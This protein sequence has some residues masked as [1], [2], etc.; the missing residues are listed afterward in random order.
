MRHPGRVSVRVTEG[1]LVVV[2]S[3]VWTEQMGK[4]SVHGTILLIAMVITSGFS[5]LIYL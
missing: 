2:S 5:A 3:H 4:K 1:N